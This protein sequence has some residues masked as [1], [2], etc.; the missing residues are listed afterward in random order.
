MELFMKNVYNR[1]LKGDILARAGNLS[2]DSERKLI[3]KEFDNLDEQAQKG[4]TRLYGQDMHMFGYK[5]YK[6]SKITA[7]ENDCC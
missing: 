1:T 7:C 4:M 6:K 3:V 5:F 2:F